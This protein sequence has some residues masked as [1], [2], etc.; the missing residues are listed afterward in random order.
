MEDLDHGTDVL[1]LQPGMA[2]IGPALHTKRIKAPGRPAP[3]HGN[4]TYIRLRIAVDDHFDRVTRRISR[5]QLIKSSP[6]SEACHRHSAHSADG[7]LLQDRPSDR[8]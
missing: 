4:Q 8:Q 2:K 5:Y 6:R 3:V 7:A 1:L